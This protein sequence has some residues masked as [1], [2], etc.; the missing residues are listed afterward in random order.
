[1]D[2]SELA[3]SSHTFQARATDPAGNV[4]ASTSYTWHVHLDLP[5]IVID[6][7]NPAGMYNDSGFNAGCGTST[8]DLCGTAYDLMGISGVS[9]SLRHQSTGL[10]WNGM[11][12][13]SATE[14]FLPA[15]DT[16]LWSYAMDPA[17]FPAEGSYTLRV[18]TADGVG[19]LGYDSRTFTIDRTAPAAPTITSGQSGTT[20]GDGPFSF[21]FT[22]EPDASFQ[23]RLDA[24]TWAT[25]PSPQIYGALTDGSHT[26]DV[27]AVDGAGKPRP[28]DQ[29]DVDV[30][31][32]RRR[33]LMTFPTATSYNLPGWAAGCGT[34]TTG[35]VRDRQ[36]RRQRADRGR[37][38]HPAGQH[39]H[40]LERQRLRRGQRDLAGRH[41]D[42]VLVILVRRYQPSPPTAATPCGG[43]PPTPSAT[44]PP[45][46]ST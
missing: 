40:L 15:T 29:P 46:G 10:Y 31:A 38:Q 37:R 6:F 18:Q 2:Y 14:V 32:T 7:P 43:G 3:E 42:H 20:P 44:R 4:S 12:F 5:T 25:C 41:R 8:G 19:N 30:D 24:G 26:F 21:T 35:R 17:S 28:D 34:P 9:V 23:C 33:Q 22:G 39:E 16:T 36:R 11:T 1:V 45:V 27:R 13:A